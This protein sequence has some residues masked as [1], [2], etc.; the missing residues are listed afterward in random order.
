[1]AYN[2]L[3]GAVEGSVD[4]HADQEINGIKI[5]KNTISASAFW[6]TDDGMPCITENNV[7]ITKISNKTPGGLLVY[8]GDKTASSHHSLNFDGEILTVHHAHIHHLSGDGSSLKGVPAEHLSGKVLASQIQLG[9]EFKSHK[10]LLKINIKDGLVSNDEGLSVNLGTQ[11]GLDFKNG[12]IV[13]NPLNAPDVKANG[14]NMRDTDLIL[15]YDMREKQ[16]KHTTFRNVYDSYINTRV[17]NAKGSKNCVQ[18]RGQRTFEGNDSFTYEPENKTLTVQGQIRTNTSEISTKLEI[19]GAA[20]I[21]GAVYKKIITVTDSSYNF[22]SSDNTILFDTSK[23]A[24][25]AT[26]PAA[27]ENYGRILT[28]KKIAADEN[29]YK[30]KGTHKLLIKTEG[31]SIDFSKEITLTSNYSSRVIQSDGNKWWI[32]N[33]SGT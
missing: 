29:K 20:E 3:K 6:D 18:F 30:V 10:G 31:E 21:N 25:T 24:I 28:I 33:R 1:M 11:S 16:I 5:F 8:R 32:I 19:N 17:P 14:Q 27:S 12:K 23:G 13:L 2:L 7:G 26:L 4:Q 22:T 9:D 15:I